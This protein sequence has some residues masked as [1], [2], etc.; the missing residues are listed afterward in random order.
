MSVLQEED[1]TLPEDESGN[2]KT[3]KT[4]IHNDASLSDDE[5]LLNVTSA[6][7]ATDHVTLVTT[8]FSAN[9]ASNNYDADSR[10]KIT[11]TEVYCTDP[12]SMEYRYLDSTKHKQDIVENEK[13]INKRSQGLNLDKDMSCL[14]QIIPATPT[15]LKGPCLKEHNDCRTIKDMVV[16]SL[17]PND[18]TDLKSEAIQDEGSSQNISA[19]YES[20]SSMVNPSVS[21][22]LANSESIWQHSNLQDNCSNLEEP[23]MFIRKISSDSA[24]SLQNK[25]DSSF[26][27]SEAID[28]SE[29]LNELKS[30][31][32][33]KMRNLNRQG[34]RGDINKEKNST[35]LAPTTKT[36]TF[37]AHDKSTNLKTK[38]FQG[39]DKSTTLNDRDSTSREAASWD[40]TTLPG[41]TTSSEYQ[42]EDH[43]IPKTNVDNFQSTESSQD[44]VIYQ[45]NG[46][47]ANEKTTTIP[48]LP[49]KK[50]LTKTRKECRN[51][52]PNSHADEVTYPD[53]HYQDKS[54]FTDERS[55]SDPNMF[56]TKTNSDSTPS[57]QNEANSSFYDSKAIDISEMLN[58]LISFSKQKMRNLNRQGKKG[59]INKE[60]NS[61]VVAATTKTNTFQAHDK[62]TN[63]K[64]ITF[65]V[66]DKST[67]LNDRD[68]TSREATSWDNTSLP[69]ETT[70]EYQSEDHRIPK[71]NVDNVQ[72]TKNS[73]EDLVYQGN[74]VSANE[75][76][77]TIPK[78]PSKKPLTKARK[79]CR[80]PMPD[81]RAGNIN[82]PD[83]QYQGKSAFTD[84]RSRSIVEQSHYEDSSPP[85]D[86]EESIRMNKAII[87]RIDDQNLQSEETFLKTQS[88]SSP[89]DSMLD[90]EKPFRSGPQDKEDN[91]KNNFG[92]R[93][94]KIQHLKKNPFQ[95]QTATSKA[96][97]QSASP[98]SS[99][100]PYEEL[101]LDT[102]HETLTCLDVKYQENNASTVEKGRSLAPQLQ[103]GYHQSPTNYLD[104]FEN[105][106]SEAAI[107]PGQKNEVQEM[108]V[109]QSDE[110]LS[111]I[112]ENTS[113]LRSTGECAAEEI[114]DLIQFDDGKI[115][116]KHGVKRQRIFP[117]KE[118]KDDIEKSKG[119]SNSGAETKSAM[120]IENEEGMCGGKP[121]RNFVSG[122]MMNHTNTPSYQLKPYTTS[123]WTQTMKIEELVPA[124]QASQSSTPEHSKH[125]MFSENSM[126][127]ARTSS[128]GSM[129]TVLQ[130][131]TYKDNDNSDLEP[132]HSLQ[133][134]HLNSP[135][136]RMPAKHFCL[137]RETDLNGL[138]PKCRQM[139]SVPLKRSSSFPKISTEAMKRGTWFVIEEVG[140]SRCGSIRSEK[141]FISKSIS[142]TVTDFT[143][144]E[145][146]KLS[147][148]GKSSAI[149]WLADSILKLM[150]LTLLLLMLWIL[151]TENS[152]YIFGP[153]LKHGYTA[154]E[155]FKSMLKLRWHHGKFTCHS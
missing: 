141:R 40:N 46:V 144:E 124:L 30:F 75:K 45:G 125:H 23:N 109:T 129:A 92:T 146:I 31:S 79:E 98:V 76:R 33:Q 117:S 126:E 66:Q 113:R 37:Q 7:P 48:K 44:D 143:T 107:S 149:N 142:N 65:Q 74:G 84:E 54:G 11:S 64:T 106:I 81:S 8:T 88:M 36:K 114:A 72:S 136:M 120:P 97:V 13:E 27:D 32:K 9:S 155:V 71:T 77:A 122:K 29:M 61:T 4:Y 68:S 49:S 47:S 153:G 3:D 130:F 152:E 112:K 39:Q 73:Q 134:Q 140:C 25:A 83:V 147:S 115:I 59:D 6:Y 95:A 17:F 138:C 121:E 62:S 35:V 90:L 137:S 18:R 110:D 5:T 10:G 127:L 57:L 26:Y 14:V 135:D 132:Q 99:K 63:L 150:A 55:R 52:M 2:R 82:S 96:P 85:A 104:N 87:Q 42:S 103:N 100:E 70:S 139:R 20:E 118:S 154:T 38:T 86:H 151:V 58:E 89:D 56:I 128:L 105:Y 19:H 116:A 16:K 91:N 21:S 24:P 80:N 93:K 34:K 94:N 28:K 67:T 60:K 22:S 78:L 133:L 148:F 53:V 108:N 41:E 102:H 69:S 145:N 101:M 1:L 50:P 43:R 131:S 12:T 15:S 51:P 111:I 119:I 123:C